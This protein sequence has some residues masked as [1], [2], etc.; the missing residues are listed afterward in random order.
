MV[1]AYLDALIF[2]LSI[3]KLVT[4]RRIQESRTFLF[5]TKRTRRDLG[6]SEKIG[7]KFQFKQSTFF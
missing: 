5:W 6:E 2:S 3:Y 1:K 4:S 7:N